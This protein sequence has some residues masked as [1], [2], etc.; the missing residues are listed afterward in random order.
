[1][2]SYSSGDQIPA[3]AGGFERGG[4]SCTR[5]ISCREDI[6]SFIASLRGEGVL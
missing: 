3:D 2:C 6:T 5:L 1:M 4:V